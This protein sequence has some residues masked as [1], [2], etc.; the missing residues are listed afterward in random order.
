MTEIL[1]A[2]QVRGWRRMTVRAFVRPVGIFGRSS[3][4][5]LPPVARAL[6]AMGPMWRHNTLRLPRYG[7]LC[8]P[9][10]AIVQHPWLALCGRFFPLS[11]WCFAYL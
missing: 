1:D 8:L 10:S 7:S 11:V 4:P 5:S 3:D 9:A 6:Q 2:F